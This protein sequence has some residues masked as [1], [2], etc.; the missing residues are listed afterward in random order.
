MSRLSSPSPLRGGSASDSE[1]GWGFEKITA[2]VSAFFD[3]VYTPT[4]PLL[5][6]GHPPHPRFARG[7]G[8]K[9]TLRMPRQA[10]RAS[11]LALRLHL[12]P[13]PLI[14]AVLGLVLMAHGTAPAKAEPSR[15]IVYDHDTRIEVIEEG[16]GPLIVM[17][18]SRGRGAE[19]FDKIASEL[20][21][22]GFRVLRP[23][24]RGAALSRG[25][26]Q[27]L[28]LHDLASDVAAV[29]RIAGGGGP[30]IIV[31]HAFGSWVARMV[32]VDHPELVRG[33]VLVAAAA[34]AYPTGFPGA[35]ELS[36]AVRKSGDFTLSAAERMKYLRL[37]FF[38]PNSDATIWLHGWHPDADEAQSAAGR[39]TGQSEWWSGGAVPLLDLQG[40]LD[41]FKPRAMAN[42]MR[43]EFGE[44]VSVVVIA[45]ASHALIPEQPAAVTKAILA[46]INKLPSLESQ[47]ALTAK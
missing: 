34:K 2:V 5:R 3:D 22:A 7:G 35:S 45:N 13:A 9:K 40:E 8:M 28:T 10:E 1:P 42:E 37:A 27:N 18:P 14:I 12:R 26:M 6:N 20:A 31:G 21:N 16:R 30:A 17:L 15:E 39:A 41:P 36:E 25:S 33:V 38:A 46:W 19:D 23:E 47:G 4:R 24:P 44:R 32:A 43:D 29:I 11:S